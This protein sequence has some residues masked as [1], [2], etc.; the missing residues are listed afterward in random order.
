MLK[1]VTKAMSKQEAIETAKQLGNQYSAYGVNKVDANGY[2]TGES[3]W[4]VEMDDTM[5]PDKIFGYDATEFL[6]RQYKTK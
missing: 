2:E 4:F 1:T 6:A 3:D 5:Q